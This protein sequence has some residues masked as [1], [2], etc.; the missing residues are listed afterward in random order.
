MGGQPP[1]FPQPESPCVGRKWSTKPKFCILLE[2]YVFYVGIVCVIFVELFHKHARLS[3]ELE[4]AMAAKT[5][6]AA[7]NTIINYEAASTAVKT[8]A[9]MVVVDVEAAAS[10]AAPDAGNSGSGYGSGGG[11]GGGGS[12]D[13]GSGEDN[14]SDESRN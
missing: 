9:V 3:E 11:G 4:S 8:A 7:G 6:A 2:H 13:V 5:E 1:E 14:G 12:V 10:M